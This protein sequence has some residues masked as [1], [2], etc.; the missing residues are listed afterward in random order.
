MSG[1]QPQDWRQLAEERG[2][3]LAEAEKTCQAWRKTAQ[4]AEEWA[5][6]LGKVRQ[7]LQVQ[8]LAQSR[9]LQDAHRQR[10]QSLSELIALREQCETAKKALVQKSEE[11]SRLEQSRG[12][13]LVRWVH[14]RLLPPQTLRGRLMAK[15]VRVTLRLLRRSA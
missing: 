8:L 11:L 7:W 6:Q 14:H 5:D 13:R 12:L 2:R 4:M 9:E 10:E 15:S 3:A 1:D